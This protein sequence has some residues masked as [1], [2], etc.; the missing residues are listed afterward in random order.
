MHFQAREEMNV[1]RLNATS[2]PCAMG[3]AVGSGAD[4]CALSFVFDVADWIIDSAGA[5]R[6]RSL[7][8]I[9]APC[10]SSTRA[11]GQDRQKNREIALPMGTV[12]Q[13]L[14]YMQA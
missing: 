14:S 8:V 6:L 12:G 11:L 1:Q 4:S 5:G 3:W 9:A 13:K 2:M 7:F 10:R